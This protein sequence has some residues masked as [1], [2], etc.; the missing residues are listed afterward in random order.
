MTQTPG[1][2]GGGR[3]TWGRAFEFKT[4]DLPAS[5]GAPAEIDVSTTAVQALI[6]VSA[7]AFL[8]FAENS[9]AAST[10][11]GAKDALTI[12]ANIY[13]PVPCAGLTGKKLFI[14]QVTGGPTSDGLTH[15]LVQEA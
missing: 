2:L 3:D 5:G 14:E 1:Q 8:V 11:F 4:Q 6:R 12:D 15:S 10:A 9:A 7:A 13:V